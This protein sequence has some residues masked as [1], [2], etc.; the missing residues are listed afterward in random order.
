MEPMKQKFSALVNSKIFF[1]ILLALPFVWIANAFRIGELFYGEVIHMSGVFSAR[2]LLLTLAITP[3]RLLFSDSEWPNWLLH[4]RRYLGVATFAYAALHTVVYLD[5]KADARLIVQDAMEFSMWTGWL[6]M[7]IF[8]ALA[9]TSNDASVKNMKR[10]WKKLHRW[11]YLAAVL[12]FIHWI[13]SAFDFI[14]GLIHFVILLSLE[15]YRMWKRR[16]LKRV[17]RLT[18][19]R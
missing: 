13:F 10:A 1:C 16:D 12:T 18:R 11:V 8:A 15:S 3:M 9:V 2:L 14:P 19:L 17:A 5:H 4:R 6:A 7:L